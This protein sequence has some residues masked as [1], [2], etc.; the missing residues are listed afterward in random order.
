MTTAT[1]KK[2]FLEERKIGGSTAAMILGVS[3]WGGPAE[4]YDEIIAALDGNVVVDGTE[5]GEQ[6]RGRI[7]EPIIRQLYQEETG[8][9]LWA[10]KDKESGGQRNWTHPDFPH[11]TA[12]I[13]YQIKKPEDR[14]TPGVFEAKAPRSQKFN[15]IKLSGKLPAEW[16]CQLQ[17]NMFVCDRTWGAYGL[18]DSQTMSLLQFDVDRDDEW[19]IDVLV[20]RTLEFWA[21]HI[22]PRVRPEAVEVEAA[23]LPD[24]GLDT[25]LIEL[26]TEDWNHAILEYREVLL[27]AAL[28]KEITDIRKA[29]L[30]ELMGDGM[31]VEGAG[32]RCYNRPQK[33]RETWDKSKL[34]AY[35]NTQGLNPAGFKK[36]SKPS[37]P[38][39]T[40][41]I[42]KGKPLASV[43]KA[44]AQAILEG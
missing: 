34:E 1:D 19:C 39:L 14:P 12:H 20:P 9:Q 38:F 15:R 24:V 22:V 10:M 11:L 37:T 5:N 30:I 40:Y 33:G 21:E 36:T 4:A 8:R 31:I 44:E 43:A 7:M 16:V 29:R 23:E 3:Q 27:E 18:G 6:R 25:E 35:L 17:H 42:E 26:D 13:D 32:V 41:D 2:A 28:A